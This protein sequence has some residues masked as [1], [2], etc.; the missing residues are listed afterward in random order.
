MVD[1]AACLTVELPEDT[2]L[3]YSE[4]RALA[5]DVD[6]NALEDLVEIERLAGRMLVIPI[7]L[8]RIGIDRER[9]ARVQRAVERTN[10]SGSARGRRNL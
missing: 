2:G 9:R 4:K 10:R 7:E 5:V 3:A 8:A 1:V 6:D